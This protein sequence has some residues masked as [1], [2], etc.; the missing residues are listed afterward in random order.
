[1]ILVATSPDAVWSDLPLQPV[2]LP[3]V[4]RLVAHTA[5]IVETKRW[6][7]TGEAGPLPAEPINLTI[8][9]PAGQP[10]RIAKDS[11]RT[12]L[13]R[14][15]GFYRVMADDNAAPL[16]RFAVNTAPHESDLATVAPGEIMALLKRSNAG[17]STAGPTLTVAEQERNQSWWIALLGL[18]V[19]LLAAEALYAGRLQRPTRVGGVR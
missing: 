15:P 14:D 3:L 6:F 12:V 2:F 8:E 5:G 1:M 16:A 11:V 17:P 4:Q 13:L 9:Q 18:G 10:I 7:G 19:V